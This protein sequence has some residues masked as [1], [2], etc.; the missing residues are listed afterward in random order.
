MK[1]LPKLKKYHVKI[2]AADTY[3][4]ISYKQAK[5]LIDTYPTTFTIRLVGVNCYLEE[6][7]L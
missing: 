6:V 1:Q 3:V 7:S 2:K 4:Q 5:Q